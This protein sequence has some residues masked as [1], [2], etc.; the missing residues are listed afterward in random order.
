MTAETLKHWRTE[1]TLK[2]THPR[3][4][5]TT[6]RTHTRASPATSP[7]GDGD[8]LRSPRPSRRSS[9]GGRRHGSPVF[10]LLLVGG[11][12]VPQPRLL[13]QAAQAPRAPLL[14]LRRRHLRLLGP[15]IAR[16]RVRGASPRLAPGEFSP[17]PGR[18]RGDLI[19]FGC[20]GQVASN[21][22]R[23]W[24]GAGSGCSDDLWLEPSGYMGL[25]LCCVCLSGVHLGE[26]VPRIWRFVWILTLLSEIWS[27][28]RVDLTRDH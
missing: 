24:L 18:N 3:G 19:E 15:P 13:P 23:R 11:V 21:S 4:D 22:S 6:D 14:R 2:H 25:G 5:S 8:E 28:E 12:A 27:F 16:Q 17:D 7:E 1:K 10:V 20:C 9:I 26:I